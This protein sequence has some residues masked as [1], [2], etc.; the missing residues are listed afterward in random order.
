VPHIVEQHCEETACLLTQRWALLDAPAA[1][2]KA[3]GRLDERLA[4]H[5]DGL[6]VA[7]SFARRLAGRAAGA[8]GA[9]DSDLFAAA[10]L[11][12]EAGDLSGLTAL[13]GAPTVP[14][15]LRRSVLA[16]LGWVSA[17]ALRGVGN[18]LLD[19]PLPLNRALGLRACVVHRVDA[20]I[21]LEVALASADAGLRSCAL[22]CAGE[23]GRPERL[24]ACR[25]ALT[26]FDVRCRYS[27]ARSAILLGDRTT[28]LDV[29]AEL[30]AEPGGMPRRGMDV[31]LK[32]METGAA[33]AFLK[34]LAR[35]GSRTRDVV[36]GAGLGGDPRHIPWLIETSKTQALARLAGE[37]FCNV[38]GADLEEERLHRPPPAN[39]TAG[40]TDN[41]ADDD[42]AMDE[43]DGLPWPD[44][45]KLQAWWK[46]NQ[47][48]FQPGVRYFL[49]AP[50]TVAH[51]RQVL[52]EG[53]QRQRIAAA[54]YL[55]L[56]SPGTPLFPTSAPAWRQQRWLRQ[57]G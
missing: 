25:S 46:V 14:A 17:D 24:A 50:P 16:A 13:S 44:P 48:R 29:L 35:Q 52:R 36:R 15:G 39:F 1:G 20:G 26:D 31:L 55:C 18:A 4:A 54:E 23:S 8:P 9:A 40:P 7:G 43:D 34:D 32:R 53:Y 22:R 47:G 5:L 19:D 57:I 6:R 12:V 11:A 45:A 30:A 27:A 38:T 41:P 28:A 51:C 49:G 37:A 3:L 56:L 21:R 42:V 33:H 10:V 2:I